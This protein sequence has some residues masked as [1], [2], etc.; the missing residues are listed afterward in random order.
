MR[1]HGAATAT[2]TSTAVLPWSPFFAI[3]VAGFSLRMA[4]AVSE[5]EFDFMSFELFNGMIR[6]ESYG[7]GWNRISLS[8][9]KLPRQLSWD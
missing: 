5:L 1:K 4:S 8:I 3:I 7:A 2:A 9:G 6:M